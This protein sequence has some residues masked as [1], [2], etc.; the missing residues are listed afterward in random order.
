MLDPKKPQTTPAKKEEIEDIPDSPVEFDEPHEDF[1]S[2]EFPE[3]FDDNEEE[4]Y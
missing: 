4:D 1:G 2:D 3:D